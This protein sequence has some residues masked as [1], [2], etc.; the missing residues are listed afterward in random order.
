MIKN[1]TKKDQYLYKKSYLDRRLQHDVMDNGIAHIPCRIKDIDDI[2]SKYSVKDCESLDSEFMNFIMNFIEFIPVEYPVVIQ[3]IDPGLSQEEKRIICETIAAETDYL[4]GKT[5][6][7]LNL[8]K[9]RFTIMIAGTVISG[10]LLGIANQIFENVPLEFFYVLFWLFADA[11]VR[12]LFIDKLDFKEEKIRMGRLA[13]M[14][15]EFVKE[16]E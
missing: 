9:R 1:N 12:Y 5:E 8:Q 11:L 15:V 7:F 3:I 16:E 13:S 6:E 14:E 10:L 2:I 4:L